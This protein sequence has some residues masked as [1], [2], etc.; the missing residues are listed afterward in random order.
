[1]SELFPSSKI[2]HIPPEYLREIGV[3]RTRHT[4][5]VAYDCHDTY[6][7]HLTRAE[8]EQAYDELK[9]SIRNEGFKDEYPISICF[10]KMGNNDQIIDGHHRFNIAI[11]LGIATIPVRF[12]IDADKITLDTVKI[13]LLEIKALLQAVLNTKGGDERA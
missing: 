9:E 7:K 2:Y 3:E 4:R 8:K 12:F 11:E 1:M 6:R 10:R 13:E 5:E